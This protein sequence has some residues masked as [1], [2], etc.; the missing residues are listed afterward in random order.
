MPRESGRGARLRRQLSWVRADGL[1]RMVEEKHLHPTRRARAA[2]AQARW[3]R[4]HGV[5]PGEARPVWVLGVQRSGTNLLTRTLQGVP[6]MA[7]YSENHRRAFVDYRLRSDDEIRLLI[8]RS[9]H[10][11]V[12]FKPLCDSARALDFW[13]SHFSRSPSLVI[14]AYRSVDGRV[15]SALSRFGTANLEVMR[16]VAAGRH[17]GMWQV[18]GLGPEDLALIRRFDWG[19]DAAASAAALFWYLR[20]KLLFDRGLHVR[21][22][23][24]VFSYDAFVADPGGGAAV[25][26]RFLGVPA[27]GL[28]AGPVRPSR[29]VRFD[30]YPEVR[31][32]CD[33]LGAAL[34]DLW[35]R[36]SR[37]PAGAL[38]HYA[39]VEAG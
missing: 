35:L 16:A 33:E 8:H 6:E 39:P 13:G 12:L 4:R 1:A 10:R 30:L 7:V 15:R 32:R 22:R 17:H 34:D 28:D 19:D 14:W 21:P 5:E 27:D 29:P 38:A 36:A 37:D 31:Q 2:V 23:V 3:R 20:N 26:A 25:V 9:R 11:L 18:D 24:T